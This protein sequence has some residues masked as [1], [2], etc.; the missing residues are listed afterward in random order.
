MTEQHRLLEKLRRLEAIFSGTNFE[1]ERVA[2][3]VAM[4]KLREKLKQVEAADPP[5]PY[6]FSMT[7]MYSRKLFV[8]LLRRYGLTP[9]RFPRQRHTT[10]MVRVSKTFVDKTLWPEF[11]ELSDVLE[12]YLDEVTDRLISTNIHADTSEAETRTEPA[13]LT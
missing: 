8:A 11:V 6:K 10:V 5:V 1:G 2:A 12:S 13:R 9:F 3:S 4:E 7:D